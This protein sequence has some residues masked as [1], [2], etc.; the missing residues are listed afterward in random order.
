MK[1][2]DMKQGLVVTDGNGFG[3]VESWNHG[4]AF[5]RWYSEGG[6]EAQAVPTDRVSLSP[7]E[8]A[9]V[10]ATDPDFKVKP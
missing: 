6:F 3:L 1:I 9:P 4:T 5:V 2:R 7:V 8:L 10:V